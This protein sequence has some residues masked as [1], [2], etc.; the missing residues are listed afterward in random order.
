MCVWE[1]ARADRFDYTVCFTHTTFWYISY[2]WHRID[3]LCTFAI[4]WLDGIIVSKRRLCWNKRSVFSKEK[5]FPLV[6]VR[7]LMFCIFVSSL[8]SIHRL[9]S[10]KRYFDEP[11]KWNVADAHVLVSVHNTFST[12]S[13]SICWASFCTRVRFFVKRK[14]F[15]FI[16]VRHNSCLSCKEHHRVKL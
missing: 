14:S 15:Q 16:V 10:R 7:N 2:H 4:H 13:Q 6:Y 5:T 11:I 8:W 9:R 12:H 3:P 1:Q